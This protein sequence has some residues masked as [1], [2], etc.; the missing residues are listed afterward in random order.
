[1]L[2]SISSFLPS[3]LQIGGD[4][5]HQPLQESPTQITQSPTKDTED[6]AVDE[7]G[8]KKKKE[9]TNEAW[10]HAYLLASGTSRSADQ[11]WLGC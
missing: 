1:M 2:S 9:R 11:Q 10:P 4:K 8:V 5:P 7:H 6:M 3:A